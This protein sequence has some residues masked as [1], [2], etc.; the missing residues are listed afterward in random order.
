VGTAT[1]G[2]SGERSSAGFGLF[3]G[4]TS[5]PGLAPRTAEGGCP[6]VGF[7]PLL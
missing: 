2:L 3:L 5:E 4:L 1:L 7:T 6:Y